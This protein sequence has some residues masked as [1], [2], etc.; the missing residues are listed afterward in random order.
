MHQIIKIEND[1]DHDN[2]NDDKRSTLR[3]TAPKF[4]SEKEIK[5]TNWEGMA[6]NV[7]L[8]LE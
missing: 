1:N 7:S 2:E 6:Q 4:I 3:N 5:E 8:N